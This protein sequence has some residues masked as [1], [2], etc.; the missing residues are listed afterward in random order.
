M[1]KTA[2]IPTILGI[3]LLLAGVSIGVLFVQRE[4]IFNLSAAPSETPKEVRITN[5]TDRG[6]S[7]SWLTDK[8]TNGFISYGKNK[9]VGT[10]INQDSVQGQSSYIHHV[11]ADNLEANTSYSL[12]I[13]FGKAGIDKSKLYSVKSGPTLKNPSSTDIIFGTVVDAQ[14]KPVAGSVVY[15]T[16]PGVT[17]LSAVT[18]K[19]GKWVYVFSTARRT[20]LSA[21]A[22][23][24]KNETLLEIFV[25]AGN[26]KF[27]SAKIKT[28]AA[29]P[30][31][32][33]TLGK[34]HD[35]TNLKPVSDGKAPAS[36]LDL[37]RVEPAT[38]SSPS[39]SP[40]SG[41]SQ[42][43]A[44]AKNS[45]SPSPKGSPKPS[46]SPSPKAVGGPTS[47]SPSPKASPVASPSPSPKPAATAGSATTLTSTGTLPSAGNLTTTMFIFIIGLVLVVIGLFVPQT[48]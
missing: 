3:V 6:F 19:Q 25:Q 38:S 39:P 32:T 37:T 30:V 22:T 5:I 31:P 36:E 13:G 20:D 46:P 8:P 43:L 47:A 35:F 41:F 33:M 23:Y 48:A 27:S 4:N 29:R 15:L 21:F 11:T 24:D 34:I 17:P 2:K 42:P 16:A 18:D 1:C 7:V 9:S 14:N 10:I 40:K 44:Q 45:P 28:G 12:K 26:E